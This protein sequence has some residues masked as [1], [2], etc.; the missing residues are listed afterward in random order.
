MPL[1]VV[2]YINSWVCEDSP[3][4]QRGDG[5]GGGGWDIYTGDSPGLSPVTAD[6][7]M[8]VEYMS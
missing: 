4:Y 6:I 2:M 1:K 3:L 7:G 5:I 8:S